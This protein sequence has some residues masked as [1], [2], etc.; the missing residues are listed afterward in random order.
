MV[1]LISMGTHRRCRDCKLLVIDSSVAV[2]PACGSEQVDLIEPARL[3]FG[4]GSGLPGNEATYLDVEFPDLEAPDDESERT[5]HDN[6]PDHEL[7]R[8]T[9][10]EIAYHSPDEFH[11]LTLKSE[12]E[13]FGIGSWIRCLEPA[14]YHGLFRS[15]SVWGWLL[16]DKDDLARAKSIIREFLQ[17]HELERP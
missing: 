13:R 5:D 9:Q 8:P 7:A 12:L 10:W 15:H 6:D 11:A 3:V 2:C 16:V 1:R 4:S 14:G 17:S